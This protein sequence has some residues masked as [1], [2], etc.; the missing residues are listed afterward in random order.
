MLLKMVIPVQPVQNN[1]DYKVKEEDDYKVKEET[2][3]IVPVEFFY[4]YP[5]YSPEYCEWYFD[6]KHFTQ[7][8]FS[9]KTYHNVCLR[10]ECHP[11][12]CYLLLF[13]SKD[14]DNKE[15]RD[16]VFDVTSVI[17]VAEYPEP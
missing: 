5:N 2:V 7:A 15:K 3:I 6:P 4:S 8:E 10:K 11:D 13:V 9:P 1:D 17:V 12:I 14:E 16:R